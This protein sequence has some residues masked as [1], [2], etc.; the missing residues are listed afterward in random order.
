MKRVH[1]LHG[2]DRVAAYGPESASE[3]EKEKEER[4]RKRE[5]EG[6]LYA[7]ALYIAQRATCRATW[8][9]GHREKVTGSQFQPRCSALE[10]VCLQ[11]PCP[12]QFPSSEGPEVITH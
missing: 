10:W 3:R 4:E 12:P 2:G 1:R 9:L 5:V 6:E 8:Y 7:A 11:L